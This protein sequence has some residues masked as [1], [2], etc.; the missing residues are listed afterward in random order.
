MINQLQ[1]LLIKLIILIH[2]AK[3]KTLLHLKWNQHLVL[4]MIK[5]TC[6]SITV[7][8]STSLEEVLLV[9]VLIARCLKLKN[10]SILVQLIK[11][12]QD[13]QCQK[14]IGDY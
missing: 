6:C 13:I 8:K 3:R 7:K 11:V 9:Q 2:F 10:N 12:L 1:D 4:H 5:K 14:M